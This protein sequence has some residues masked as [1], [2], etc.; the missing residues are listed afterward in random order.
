MRL[1]YCTNI[2]VVAWKSTLCIIYIDYNLYLIIDQPTKKPEKA[3][4]RAK[5]LRKVCTHSTPVLDV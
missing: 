3:H 5:S 2:H 4:E 1:L